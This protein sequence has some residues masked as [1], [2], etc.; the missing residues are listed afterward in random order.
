MTEKKFKRKPAIIAAVTLVAITAAGGGFWVYQ[1][2]KLTEEAEGYAAQLVE[3]RE[4]TDTQLALDAANLTRVRDV[5]DGMAPAT[6]I[7]ESK[8]DFFEAQPRDL[9]LLAYETAAE[10]AAIPDSTMPVFLAPF[11]ASTSTQE[12][13]EHYRQASSEDREVLQQEHAAVLTQ[14][15][16]FD[17]SLVEQWDQVSATV[18]GAHEAATVLLESLPTTAQTLT[19]GLDEASEETVTAVHEAA[20]VVPANLEGSPLVLEELTEHLVVYVEAVIKAQENHK[21]AVAARE[22]AEKEA[23]EKAAA[24]KAAAEKA[25][26]AKKAKAGSSSG[27]REVQQLC[28]RWQASFNGGGYLVLVPCR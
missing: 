28:S 19:V 7:L 6:E 5:H 13:V 15:E 22:K 8:P 23:A 16:D 21:E 27:G 12:F 11:D 14:L 3:A 10:Y 4:V 9:F 18:D 2:T 17:T 24:E 25:A 26:A 1:D 20:G